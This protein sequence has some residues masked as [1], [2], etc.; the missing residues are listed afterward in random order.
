MARKKRAE[1]IIDDAAEIAAR[2][3][4]DRAEVE[5]QAAEKAEAEKAAERIA[6]LEA[7]ISARDAAAKAEAERLAA[8]QAAADQA[9]AARLAAVEAEAD[10]QAAESRRAL[11]RTAAMCALVRTVDAEF[12]ANIPASAAAEG[13]A[14]FSA[15]QGS[16]LA[17]RT[18]DLS[19]GAYCVDGSAWCFVFRDGVLRQAVRADRTTFLPADIMPVPAG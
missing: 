7:E 19:D 12:A 15:A 2:E 13:L 8:E 10:L 4:A 1:P 3:A 6:E 16:A 11:E 14:D 18:F 5:R 9:E 17:S